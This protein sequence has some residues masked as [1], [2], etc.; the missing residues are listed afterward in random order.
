[1][2]SV[3]SRPIRVRFCIACISS[4]LDIRIFGQRSPGEYQMSHHVLDSDL[5]YVFDI[6]CDD[7]F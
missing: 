3:I 7:V 5:D 1:M 6:T 4:V 2:M